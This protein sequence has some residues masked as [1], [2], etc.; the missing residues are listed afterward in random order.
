M[1]KQT[2]PFEPNWVVHPGATLEDFFEMNNLPKTIIRLHSITDEELSGVL[3]GDLEID[4]DL[5]H[6][7]ERMTFI[8]FNVWINL[9]HNFR[10]GLAAG[11]TWI[12]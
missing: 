6:R 10:A 12:R 8:P 7:L 3:S 9:E 11:L 4:E 1:G 5:A 2:Y